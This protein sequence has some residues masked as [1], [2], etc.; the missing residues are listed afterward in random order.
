MSR[1]GLI[2]VLLALLALLAAIAAITLRSGPEPESLQRRT[3]RSR[4]EPGPA[5]GDLPPLPEP[6]PGGEP[7]PPAPGE[8]GPAILTGRVLGPDG[9]AV[10][11]PALRAGEGV[12]GL[13]PEAPFSVATAET[14]VDLV[15]SARDLLPRRV[16]VRGLRPDERRDLGEIRLEPGLVVGGR[17]TDTAGLP[18]PGLDVVVG[19]EARTTDRN[20]E[21]RCGGLS[22]EEVTV[23]ID[24]LGFELVGPP[25]VVRPPAP[26]VR[27]VVKRLRV[28]TGRVVVEGE[29]IGVPRAT[30]RLTITAG[31]RE[32]ARIV[33]TMDDGR[34]AFD[35]SDPVYGAPGLGFVVRASA[36][37]FEEGARE[38]L[39]LADLLPGAGFT[40]ALLRGVPAEPGRLRGRV[41]YDTGAPFVGSITLSF[42]RPG[43]AGQ[44]LRAETD[45]QG[46]FVVDGVLP[47]EYAL[48][49]ALRDEERLRETGRTLVIVS[50]GEA[51]ADL[52]VPRGGDV[53]VTVE[54]EGGELLEGAK[55]DLLDGSGAVA[56][57]FEAGAGRVLIHDLAPGTAVLRV[58]AP[59]RRPESVEVLVARDTMA[60]VRVRLLEDR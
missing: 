25:R 52:V 28:A 29:E 24:G 51:E 18:V 7:Q 40:L 30:V 38:G 26:D 10:R 15:F 6:G 53:E 8:A 57:T 17:V 39:A 31:D 60:P 45:E 37:G 5:T 46:L 27:L 54:D 13:D 48:R 42:S 22:P 4:P 12:L 16:E 20:G 49:S 43:R 9:E 1:A 35:L 32:E 14:D 21:F 44:I 11:E 56:R 34:F 19:D 33:Q 47:G 55:V 59:G 23:G 2:A 36:E 50:G 41:L 3:A 58:T